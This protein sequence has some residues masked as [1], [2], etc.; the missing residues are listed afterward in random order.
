MSFLKDIKEVFDEI[1][2]IPNQFK[3]FF[4]PVI[5]IAPL[6]YVALYLFPTSFINDHSTYVVLA[7]TYSLSMV[8]HIWMVIFA[9]MMHALF[10][11]DTKYFPTVAPIFYNSVILVMWMFIAYMDNYSFKS[12]LLCLT[13]WSIMLVFIL[14]G[15]TVFM[16][17]IVSIFSKKFTDDFF[18]KKSFLKGIKGDYYYFKY[19]DIILIADK[20][21][22]TFTWQGHDKQFY[23]WD[24]FLKFYHGKE[25]H[26]LELPS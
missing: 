9:I 4:A 21:K 18:L 13:I 10:F 12:F 11:K 20:R 1:E 22:W 17:W 15:L 2:K 6:W 14:T 5:F 24:E 19:D 7:C 25:G 8:S 23:T 26:V 16:E 3:L